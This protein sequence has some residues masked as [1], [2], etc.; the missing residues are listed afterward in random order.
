MQGFVSYL[1]YGI[2]ILWLV[3]IAVLVRDKMRS[4]KESAVAQPELAAGGGEIVPGETWMGVYMQDHKIGYVHSRFAKKSEG[5]EF[6]QKSV[7]R[8]NVMG[9]VQT[10]EAERGGKDRGDRE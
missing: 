2:V 4:V 7:L 10:P 8:L 3:L 9:S 5:Y 1:R 6:E